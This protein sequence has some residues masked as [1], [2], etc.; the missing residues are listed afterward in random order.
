ME[1]TK[2]TH[3]TCCASKVL[4]KKMYEFYL[5][6][7][8][9]H[10]VEMVNLSQGWRITHLRTLWYKASISVCIWIFRSEGDI[11]DASPTHSVA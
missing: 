5:C 2:V 10:I 1:K 4:I 9:C 7:K 11:G 8:M 6:L 3:E